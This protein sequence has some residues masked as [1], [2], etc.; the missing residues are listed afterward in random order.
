MIYPGRMAILVLL[1]VLFFPSYGVAQ[2]S[3]LYSNQTPRQGPSERRQSKY[4]LSPEVARN[5]FVAVGLPAP[6]K[7]ALHDLVTVVV[8]ESI[9]NNSRSSLTTQKDFKQEGKIEAIPRLRLQDFVDLKI[10]QATLD[11]KPEVALGFNKDFEGDGAHQQRNTF[12]ARITARIIDIKPN[13][14]L[15]LEARKGI[16]TDNEAFSMVLTGTCRR[17]DITA[18]NTVLSTELYDLLIVKQHEGELH[19]A[20]KKG[21]LAKLFDAI[22]NF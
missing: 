13:G 17:E 20:T 7:Y 2:S 10:R 19:R 3:S 16:K 15:V 9:S 5:S 12:I 22:F 21:P 8:R 14:T 18:S 4:P 6:R 11:E 1:G